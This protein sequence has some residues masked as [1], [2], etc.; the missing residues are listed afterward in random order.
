VNNKVAVKASGAA[1]AGTPANWTMISHL[2]AYCKGV[3]V[4]KQDPTSGTLVIDLL[5]QPSSVTV[6]AGK[7]DA[8]LAAYS[9][10]WF[11]V[12]QDI[13]QREIKELPTAVKGMGLIVLENTFAENKK[14]FLN[15]YCIPVDDKFVRVGFSNFT[16]TEDNNPFDGVA[17]VLYFVPPPELLI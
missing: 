13:K 12:R 17:E 6:T 14:Y 11:N 3:D 2:L 8:E 9:P 10:R 16:Q 4:H 7:N 1:L 15:S 5:Y